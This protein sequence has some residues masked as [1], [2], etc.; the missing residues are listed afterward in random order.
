[1]YHVYEGPEEARKGH[2]MPWNWSY[3]MSSQCGYWKMSLG[4]G[5][6]H[7]HVKHEPSLK[8]LVRE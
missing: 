8:P 1:M 3:R 2:Q 6:S 7:E 4:P 5:R